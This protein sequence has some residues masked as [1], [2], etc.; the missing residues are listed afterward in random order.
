MKKVLCFSMALFLCMI[1]SY[2]QTTYPK[3]KVTL[4][5][6]MVEKGSKGTLDKESFSFS[7][8]SELKTYSLSDVS[9]IQA[10]KGSGGTWAAGCAGG[11]LGYLIVD[12][13]YIGGVQGIEDGG[14]TV[15]AFMGLSVLCI[16]ASAGIGYLIGSAFDKYEIVYSKNLSYLQH[17]D[18]NF[19]A[20]QL[21]R[22]TPVTNNF[23]LS[24]R[25]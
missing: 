8:G 25:F 18:L 5:N 23:T 21:T 7:S 10:S 1:V 16:G 15:G 4:K 17:L 12:F 11:C 14:T 9:M 2:A 19:S 3:V 13:I 22:Y 6:G 20:S 24:Y